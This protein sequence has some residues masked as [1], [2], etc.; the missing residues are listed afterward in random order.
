MNS[1]PED[2]SISRQEPTSIWNLSFITLFFTNMAFN[3]G[4]LM[5]NSLLA[6]YA[7]SFGATETQI[8]LVISTFALAS[9]SFRF[10]SAPVMDTYNRKYI[11]VFS[12]LMLAIAFWGFSISK[13]VPM[14]IA[15]RLVQGCGMAFGNACCLAMVADMLPKD[16]YSSG[17]GY[18]SLAQVI[19]SAIGPSI[20]LWLVEMTGF[21]MTFTINAGIMLL[22]AFL[23]FQIKLDFKQGKKLVLKFDNIIAKEGLL[24]SCIL[25]F[26]LAGGSAG[27]FLIVYAASRGVT[28]Y[29]GFYF[30]VSALTMLITRPLIGRLTDKIGLVYVCIPALFSNII[31]FIIISNSSALWSFFLAS[32]IG[33]FGL[34]ACQPAFQ[35]L[36]MKSVPKERRGAASSTNFIGMDIGSMIGPMLAG[37]LA[38]SF[39]YVSMWRI[40]TIPLFMA[41]LLL[42]LTRKKVMQIE[43]DFVK[44][45]A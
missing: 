25:L 32:F 40:M 26:L 36:S 35:A 14:L 10:I 41:I 3:M 8:G 9:I 30:T 2:L 17:I 16:K 39:G 33:A 44:N 7:N 4:Q 38:Q 31:A 15:F 19:S 29:I 6:V 42:F 23:A 37:T 34:G 21:G 1:Q 22:A 18:Y 43:E 28:A 20:G 13:S 5:S 11:V 24:P 45:Q 12:T 27:S